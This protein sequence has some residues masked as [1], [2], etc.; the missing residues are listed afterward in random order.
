MLELKIPP[1]VVLIV[2]LIGMYVLADFQTSTAFP[3]LLLSVV[4]WSG[5]I[6]IA[7]V[8]LFSFY[9]AHTTIHPHDPQKTSALVVTGI[10]RYSRNP[11]YLSL[12]LILI[13]WA[14]LFTSVVVVLPI[15]CFVTYVTYFQ[16]KPE[17]RILREKFGDE[18][19]AYCRR[20]RRWL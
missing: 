11:M 19:T 20:V 16:I 10:F 2:T 14:C 8:A 3:R 9:R 15:V 13:G 4:C 5:A 1:P 12:T 6:A 18:Y 7:G 17:E